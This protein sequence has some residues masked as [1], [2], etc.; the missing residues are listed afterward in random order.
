MLGQLV[1]WSRG[2]RRVRS[3]ALA[4]L[5]LLLSGCNHISRVSSPIKK[6]TIHTGSHDRAA[7]L[8]RRG[9]ERLQS[10]RRRERE[11][12]RQAPM[13]PSA[14]R[15]PSS[16]LFISLSTLTIRIVSLPLLRSLICSTPLQW[17]GF[18]GIPRTTPSRGWTPVS[19]SISSA[20]RRRRTMFL[21]ARHKNRQR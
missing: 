7:A 1:F 15:V 3:T 13:R 17:A 16:S 10:W 2:S 18:G 19:E 9:R 8:R 6:M 12:G 11:T 4:H 14:T 5:Q 20:K 21:Q